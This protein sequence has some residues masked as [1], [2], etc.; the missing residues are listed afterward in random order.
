MKIGFTGTQ[1]G[2]T[3]AQKECVRKG[4]VAG[5]HFHHGACVGSDAEAHNIAKEIGSYIV[6]H[7]PVDES[8][9]VKC[10]GDECRTSAKYLERDHNIVDETDV[11]YACPKSKR[12]ILRSG[13]WATIRYAIKQKK[14][15][16]IFWP[17][18]TVEAR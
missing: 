9:M 17:D 7:P 5:E 6:V 4:L 11:L 1:K 16:L 12:E 18:G 10:E 3:D 8:K 14:V 2:M 13:T 15:V